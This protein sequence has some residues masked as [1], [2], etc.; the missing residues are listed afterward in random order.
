MYRAKY[1]DDFKK[2]ALLSEDEIRKYR[3]NMFHTSNTFKKGHL[4]RVEIT[5]SAENLIFPNQ[6]TGNDFAS[7]TEYVIAHQKIYHNEQ[8]PSHISVPVMDV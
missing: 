8:Y 1:I 4:I 7:D 2:E 5:S 3:I 6:N